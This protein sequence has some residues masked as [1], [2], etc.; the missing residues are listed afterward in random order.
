MTLSTE[1]DVNKFLK[2][3]E[4]PDIGLTLGDIGRVVEVNKSDAAIAIKVELETAQQV[5]GFPVEPAPTNIV[6]RPHRV[7]IG[8]YILG[9]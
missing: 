2:S 3:I 9:H 5:P 7:T 6:N 1:S 4:L 8:K